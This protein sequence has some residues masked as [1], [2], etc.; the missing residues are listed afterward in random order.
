[1][2]NLNKPQAYGYHRL[3]TNLEVIERLC[4]YDWRD[5]YD[6]DVWLE[7]NNK[8]RKLIYVP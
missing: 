6:L 1:M 2:K 7:A 5:I 4:I 3:E 8:A